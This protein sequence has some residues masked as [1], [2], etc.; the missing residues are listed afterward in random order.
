[1]TAFWHNSGHAN[2]SL[3]RLDWR[4]A[5]AEVL[6]IFVGIT[7]AILFDNWNEDR[8]ERNL[9]RQL[10]AEVRD[11]LAETR[12]DLLT[13]I[14]SIQD[15]MRD[16]RQ[17]VADW[18][19]AQSLDRA[20]ASQLVGTDAISVM[21]PKTSG[22]R[23]LTSQ[24]LGIISDPVVRKAITDFYELRLERITIYESLLF[25][26]VPDEY[27]PY[28]IEV[29]QIPEDQLRKGIESPEQLTDPLALVP[30]D[31]VALRN[32]SRMPNYLFHLAELS[33]LNADLYE[34]TLQ[35]IDALL[36]LIDAHLVDF[37]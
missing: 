14:D 8:K 22:Y 24:G 33:Q 6:L 34:R 9:E 7:L 16:L 11:D 29:T 30:V 27:L 28:L 3:P 26:F 37:D 35:D 25:D 31:G 15:R 2:P 13:D 17:L 12:A 23:S 1:M 21:F 10:L 5:I 20:W 4:R 19:P 36:V 32:D 18:I